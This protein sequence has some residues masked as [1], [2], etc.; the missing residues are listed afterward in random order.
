VTGCQDG[1]QILAAFG[2]TRPR[3]YREYGVLVHRSV[4][5]KIPRDVQK[6]HGFEK[7]QAEKTTDECI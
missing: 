7:L 2:T 1:W 3:D 5:V 6:G 4:V